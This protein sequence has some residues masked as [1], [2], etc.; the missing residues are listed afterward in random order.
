M[1]RIAL[2]PG[3]FDPFTKGHEDV[4]RRSLSLFDEV[5]VAIGFNSAKNRRY[6]DIDF[7]VEKIN[8]VFEGDE[9]V[10]VEVYNELTAN[11]AKKRGAIALVRGLRNTTDFE[12]E[13]SIS[14]INAHL[15]TELETV[16]LITDPVYAAVSSTIIREVH[17]YDGDVSD[18][19]PYKL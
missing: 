16:F 11:F 9:R 2:F 4:V 6:F 18:F 8:S 12:Y 7:M 5:I 3:S 13:N 17:K 14:Q 15:N 19:L 1:K 10:K